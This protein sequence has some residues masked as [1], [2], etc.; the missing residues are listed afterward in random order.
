MTSG[1]VVAVIAICL[2]GVS[3]TATGVWV[4]FKLSFFAG[5]MHQQVIQH[6]TRITNLEGKIQ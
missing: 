3:M 2:T 1:M 5:E 6:E 4:G